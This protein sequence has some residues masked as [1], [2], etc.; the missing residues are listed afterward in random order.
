MSLNNQD[1]YDIAVAKQLYLER[2]KIGQRERAEAIFQKF[3]EVFVDR[4]FNRLAQVDFT[5][6]NSRAYKR[7]VSDIREIEKELRPAYKVKILNLVK[8]LIPVES[9]LQSNLFDELSEDSEDE[10]VDDLI[11]EEK[12]EIWRTVLTSQ[13][14]E[15]EYTYDE[16]VGA[17][18]SSTSRDVVKILAAA[19]G[20]KQPIVEVFR[21]VETVKEKRRP[22]QALISTGSQIVE[23]KVF[24]FLAPKRISV[25]IDG[26]R[27]L[28]RLK[29][30]WISVIDAVTTDYCRDQNGRIYDVGKGPLPP[31]HT[32]CRSTVANYIEG[33][34]SL[35]KRSLEE[36]LKANAEFRGDLLSDEPLTIAQYKRKVKAYVAS[37]N[38]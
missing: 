29:Y 21:A 10:I 5:T 33:L 8:R 25:T 37:K 2:L 6:L 11:E 1:L 12:S 34:G 16:F 18:F 15:T 23:S 24:D 36:F 31:A 28:S 38:Q 27:A 13:V 30:I 14:P 4:V 26:V 19:W 7:L 32:G 9:D 35:K 3:L 17:L 20:L 22:I